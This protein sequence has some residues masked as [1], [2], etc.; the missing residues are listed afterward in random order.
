MTRA[1]AVAVKLCL[2]VLVCAAAARASASYSAVYVGGDSMS[3]TLTRGD[4]VVLARDTSGVGSG[5][6]VLFDKPGWPAGVVHRVIAVTFEDRLRL[7]GDA[8][9]N[10]DRDELP[11][12]ALRGVVVLTLPTGRAIAVLEAVVRMVQSRVT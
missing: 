4:L 9:L 3:P 8:N 5:D 11:R 12:S 1:R 6:V 7:K 10:P 2:V